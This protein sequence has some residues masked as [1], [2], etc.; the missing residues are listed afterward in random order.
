MTQLENLDQA[1]AA[2]DPQIEGRYIYTSAASVP[3]G[4][5]PFAVIR[6]AEGLTLVVPADQAAQ[7]GFN[8]ADVFTRITA[9]AL[10]SLL[11]VGITATITSTVAS[12]GIPCNVIAGLHHDYF[13]VPSDREDEALA[14]M[15]ALSTQ[16]EG[17]LPAQ[18]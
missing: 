8:D 15:R 12:R 2:L 11:S 14:L 13:F 4:L 1:L 10:T 6:E 18:G 9:R 7:F 3:E 17:W 5:E 16:A